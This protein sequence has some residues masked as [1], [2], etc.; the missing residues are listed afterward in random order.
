MGPSLQVAKILSIPIKLHWTFILMLP[1]GYYLLERPGF[2]K[3]SLVYFSILFT[4]ISICVIFHEYGHALAA[5]YYGIKTDDIILSPLFGVARI[6]KLPDTPFGEFIVAFAGPAVNILIGLLLFVYLQISE[7]NFLST[8]GHEFHQSILSEGKRVVQLPSDFS[9]VNIALAILI[10]VNL[11]LVVFNLIP[12]FPMDGGRMFRAVLNQFMDKLVATKWAT[13]VGKIIAVFMCIISIYFS[14]YMMAAVAIFIF[15]MAA[16]EYRMVRGEFFRNQFVVGEMMMKSFTKLNQFNT[17]EEVSELFI[18]GLEKN[19][20]IYDSENKLKGILIKNKIIEWFT[21]QSDLL[22]N[23]LN[24]YMIHEFPFI[25]DHMK[26]D[27]AL[28]IMRNSNILFLPVEKNGEIIGV[29]NR[30]SIYEFIDIKNK[31]SH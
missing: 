26:T 12:A 4:L 16:S 8:L 21:N 18:N 25:Q 3:E 22:N 7:P 1:L 23:N 20:L 27:E 17:K 6:Q 5:K 14:Q 10:F 9:K 11:G 15:Y 28:E 30:R 24:N 31:M 19:F 13:F 29:V 2:G